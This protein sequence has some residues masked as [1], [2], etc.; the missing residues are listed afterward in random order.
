M[1]ERGREDSGG[2]EDKGGEMWK[3]RRNEKREWG[4][5]IGRKVKGKEE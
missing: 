3:W 4:N 5:K 2:G 1:R